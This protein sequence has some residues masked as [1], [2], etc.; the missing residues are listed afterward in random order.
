MPANARL[1]TRHDTTTTVQHAAA[2]IRELADRPPDRQLHLCADGADL[3]AFEMAA[4]TLAAPCL[5][6]RV[7]RG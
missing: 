6:I 5:R 4:A 3:L 2:M 1:H 7:R